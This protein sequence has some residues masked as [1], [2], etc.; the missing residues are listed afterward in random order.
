MARRIATAFA[1]L[2]TVGALA[3]C[4]FQ[5]LYG[6]PGYQALPGLEIEAPNDRLGYLVDDA[7]R[8]YLGGGRSQYR[9]ELETGYAEAP[10][11]IS[12]AGRA[13]RFSALVSAQ[14]HLTGP[15]GFSHRGSISETIFYDAPSD[16]Y[17]L[18]A[19]Q[20]AAQERGAEQLAGSLA[21]EFATVLRRVEAGLEP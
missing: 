13:S 7:L 21:V 15:D 19:A 1:A 4:G 18:I 12:A 9:V 16:P 14:Y 2:L 8:D 10:L 11:G 5:P 17:A 20:A 3:G 6:G